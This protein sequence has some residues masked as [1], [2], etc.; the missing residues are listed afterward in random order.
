MEP[1]QS[2]NSEYLVEET[3]IQI[4]NSSF[5]SLDLE[6]GTKA[7]ITQCYIDGEFKDRPTL[8]TAN[9]S[10]VSIQNCRFDH[11]MNEN[12]STILFGFNNSH[13]TI[14]NSVSF[15]TTIQREFCFYK[16]IHP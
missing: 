7:Q 16:I 4:Y 9:N 1:S 11:F 13:V 6:P 3:K 12:G 10:D 14:E 5:R 2:N 8:I 15:S